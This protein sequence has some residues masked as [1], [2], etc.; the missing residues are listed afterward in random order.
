M[1]DG[2]SSLT[3][4]FV[5]HD[6]AQCGLVNHNEVFLMKCLRKVYVRKR[7]PE[8]DEGKAPRRILPYVERTKQAYCARK[9]TGFCGQ[10]QAL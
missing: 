9:E 4:L 1:T 10:R 2:C 5:G 6:F 3:H 7:L 8:L